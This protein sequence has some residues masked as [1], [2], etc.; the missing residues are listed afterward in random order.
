[1][2]ID[3]AD[4]PPEVEEDHLC[5]CWKS[6]P[7]QSPP[8][9][10][11]QKQRHPQLRRQHLAR[12]NKQLEELEEVTREQKAEWKK[13]AKACSKEQEVAKREISNA[14]ELLQD[15]TTQ[16]HL[17][18]GS[19]TS[20]IQQLFAK[21]TKMENRAMEMAE[22]RIAF[23]SEQKTWFKEQDKKMTKN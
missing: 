6:P 17:K 9:F 4:K 8:N 22:W 14:L 3:N 21:T 2:N 18:E 7:V 5:N 10:H 12:T 19:L 20:K 11:H 13:E 1:M 15:A 16:S 23:Y